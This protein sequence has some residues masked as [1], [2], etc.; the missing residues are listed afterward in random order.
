MARY[1]L[2]NAV[3]PLALVSNLTSS[4]TALL[5]ASGDSAA[6]ILPHLDAGKTI[7]SVSVW[8]TAITGTPPIY[9]VRLETV[10]AGTPPRPSGTLVAVGAEGTI[11]PSAAN[12]LRTATLTTGYAPASGTMYAVVINSA[13]ASGANNATFRTT[14]ATGTSWHLPAA[15][16]NTTGS[17]V[18]AAVAPAI[19]VTYSDGTYASFVLGTTNTSRSVTTATTPDEIGNVI[20]PAVT[21]RISGIGLTARLQVSST[22]GELCI[23]DSTD[24]L[25]AFATILGDTHVMDNSNYYRI[26]TN[27]DIDVTLQAGQTYRVVWKPTTTDNSV[28]FDQSF[29]ESSDRLV[30]LGC[31]D[32][33]NH[34]PIINAYKTSRT[35]AGAW[36]DDTTTA[37]GIWPLIQYV[38]SAGLKLH[39]GMGGGIIG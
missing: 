26:Q 39:P 1:N 16:V 14:C 23:Y 3:Q 35:N 10:T 9:T 38:E 11:T 12:Q 8:V 29:A 2:A 4:G 25:L 22:D 13:S 30:W 15:V 37:A 21:A 5:D 20:I 17:W 27:D 24:S 36:T 31:Q 34:T 32:Q 18:A 19:R 6:W 7:A 33:V 28:V